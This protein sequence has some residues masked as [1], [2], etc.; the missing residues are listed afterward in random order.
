MGLYN[1]VKG[2]GWPYKRGGL[3]LGGLISGIIIIIIKQFHKY[4]FLYSF[5]SKLEMGLI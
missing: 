3:Y 1:F 5:P 2:F 4:V